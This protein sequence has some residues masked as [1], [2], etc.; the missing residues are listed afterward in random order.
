MAKLVLNCAK[1]LTTEYYKIFNGVYNDFKVNSKEAYKFEL[2]PLPCEDF[3]ES[4][5][6]GLIDCY[7][8]LEDEIPTGF[9]AYTTAISEA[10]ELNIIHCLGSDNINPKRQIL[11]AK[12]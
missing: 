3:L 1:K 2:E 7:I 6:A 5:D 9:L 11:L 12:F 8:L 4:V 10:L